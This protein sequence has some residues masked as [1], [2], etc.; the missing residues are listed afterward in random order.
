MS[1]TTGGVQLIAMLWRRPEM[2]PEEFRRHWVE[3][4]GPLIRDTPTLARHIRRYEQ[5]PRHS[6][7]PESGSPGCDGVTIQWFDSIDDLWAFT[8]EDDYAR[9]VA[10][11]ERSFLD[12]KELRFV[13]VDPPI[14]V[15]GDTP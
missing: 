14:V 15:I 8:A 6:A 10:P 4:H 13:M 12:R 9:L 1:E 2:T 5:Y 3:V 7:G 11:D